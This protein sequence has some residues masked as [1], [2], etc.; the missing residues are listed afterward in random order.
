[1]LKVLRL[2]NE[3]WNSFELMEN[4]IFTN[5]KIDTDDFNRLL[6][7]EGFFGLFHNKELIGYLYLKSMG[8][9]AHLNRIGVQKNQQGQG[10]G[11]FLMEYAINHF[12]QRS[13]KEIGL[14]VEA[15]NVKAISLYKRYKFSIKN[16]SWHFIIDMTIFKSNF[17][18]QNQT[19]S[20]KIVEAKKRDIPNIIHKFPNLNKHQLKNQMN[21]ESNK[22]SPRNY[23][24][25]LL[26]NDTI[27][28]FARFNPLYS[29]CMPFVYSEVNYVDIFIDILSESYKL[30]DKDYIR[31]TF[32]DSEELVKL[33][34]QRGYKMHH[35]LYKMVN[36]L[37]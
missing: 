9:Y 26:E 15:N 28:I 10:Y 29:G 20:F 3:N 2:E 16:E 35:H 25:M 36:A 21:E 4:E 27:K 12:K 14:Y 18:K 1:M 37:I 33:F 34:K 31:L 30:P 6:L 23:F 13:A 24:L 19:D 5:D 7:E 17:N 32:D 11:H 8:D 22:K